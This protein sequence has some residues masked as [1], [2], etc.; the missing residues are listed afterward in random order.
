MSQLDP[1]V[2][3]QADV[4]PLAIVLA[5]LKAHPRIGDLLGDSEHVSG[6]EEAPWPHLVVTE[7]IASDLR[8]GDWEAEH[9]IAFHLLGH[10]GGAPGK[11]GVRQL[12]AQVLRVALDL[13]DGPDPTTTDPVVSDV[14]P[15]GGFIWHPLA[16][17]QPT[18]R[19]AI[20]FVVHP[21]LEYPPVP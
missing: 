13:A 4:D 12:A 21:P 18:Y 15:S 10:P 20:R 14:R 11:A 1:T 3:H 2:P 8:R 17:G 16:N 5:H 7:G 19:F 9:E 6:I